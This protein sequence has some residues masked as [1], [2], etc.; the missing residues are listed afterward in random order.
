MTTTTTTI[1]MTLDVTYAFNGESEERVIECL[2]RAVDHAIGNGLLTNGTKAE[3]ESHSTQVAVRALPL[4]E[5]ELAVFMLSRIETGD[6]A[7]EDIPT[8][9]AR[10]GLMA[11]DA[12]IEEMRERMGLQE[13]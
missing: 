8:R 10:Y 6:L 11:P 4:S 13:D 7:L 5:D 2:K 12:F 1:R 9:L 3:V